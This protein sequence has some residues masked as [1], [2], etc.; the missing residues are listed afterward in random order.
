MSAVV[1]SMLGVLRTACLNPSTWPCLLI[2]LLSIYC[3]TWSRT[4]LARL[5]NQ[6]PGPAY[7]PLLVNVFEL[8]NIDYLG[9]FLGLK[10]YLML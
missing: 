4:R 3:F 2:L 10:Y 6:L 7:L 1:L 8:M 9:N 5:V